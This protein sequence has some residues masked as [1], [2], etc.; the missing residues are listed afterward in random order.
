[1]TDDQTPSQA[2]EA[3]HSTALFRAAMGMLGQYLD[4]LPLDRRDQLLAA[5]AHGAT[6][7]MRLVLPVA[8]TL[9]DAALDLLLPDGRRIELATVN[10]E[11]TAWH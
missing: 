7:H 4:E 11:P 5:I 8:P 2:N 10:V 6:V 9:P 1:M 3:Q